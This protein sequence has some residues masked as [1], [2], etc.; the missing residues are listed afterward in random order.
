MSCG[1]PSRWLEAQT[2]RTLILAE[3]QKRQLPHD[4]GS[5]TLGLGLLG[6]SHAY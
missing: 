5:A 1:P 4:G 2:G 6:D 3:R